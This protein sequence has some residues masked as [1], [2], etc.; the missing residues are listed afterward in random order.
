MLKRV[1]LTGFMTCGKST[2]GPVLANTL[3]WEFLDLDQ[4]IEKQE[5]LSVVRIFELKGEEYFRNLERQVLNEVTKRDNIIVALGGGTI[6]NPV[7]FRM[8]KQSGKIIYLQSS[9]EKIY[10][11]IKGKLDRPLFKDLVMENRPKEDFIERISNLLNDRKKY[12]EKADYVYNTDVD[13]LGMTID[14]IAKK[15]EKLLNEKN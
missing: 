11:R 5:T 10:V 14:L 6:T 3:G 1:Y 9:P 13:S 7:N 15:I 8:M 4:V 12:Y 2:I